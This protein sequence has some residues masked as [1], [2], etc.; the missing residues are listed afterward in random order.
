MAFMKRLLNFDTLIIIMRKNLLGLC[1]QHNE[2]ELHQIIK[3]FRRRIAYL[4]EGVVKF[5]KE[6]M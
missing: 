2:I 5:F 6:Q 4:L 1:L 3:S